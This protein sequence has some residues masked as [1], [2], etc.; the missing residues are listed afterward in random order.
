[1][2]EFWKISVWIGFTLTACGQETSTQSS[3]SPANLSE[4]PSS[5][6]SQSS[7]ENRESA[8]LDP[9]SMQALQD[10]IKAREALPGRQHYDANCSTCHNGAVKKAPHKDMIGL[11]TAE[12]I[13]NT[14]TE[15]VMQQ[16][17]ANL[18]LQQKQEVA[19]YLAGAAECTPKE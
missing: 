5:Q 13:L 16:E 14:L 8:Q 6:T 10:A 15:G 17:A 1:M 19:E 3:H 11:M 9:N 12:S 18:S 7:Q 2:K 4:N